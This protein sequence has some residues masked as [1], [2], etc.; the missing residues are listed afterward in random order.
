VT[1]QDAEFQVSPGSSEWSVT[2]RVVIP[3]RN[4]HY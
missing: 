2:E 3:D 1:V 4:V